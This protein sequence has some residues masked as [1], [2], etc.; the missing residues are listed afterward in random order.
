M[1]ILMVSTDD[2]VFKQPDE[3]GNTRTR[4]RDYL[5]RLNDIEPGSMI[6]D[7]VSTRNLY[8]ELT[9]NEGLKFIPVHVPTSLLFPLS[10]LFIA[11]R[12]IT[13]VPDLVTSQN[14]FE[15]GLLAWILSLIYHIPLE[16]QVHLNLF[17]PYWL[18]E[19][20]WL[21]KLRLSLAKFLTKRARVIR[22]VQSSLQ[23]SM[24]GSW[25]LPPESV[26]LIPV[27]VFLNINAGI[28]N[29]VQKYKFEVGRKFI[30]FIGRL[31][32]AK[33]LPGLFSIIEK[34]LNSRKDV[35]F[36]IIGDG[37]DR[38]FVHSK[39][40]KLGIDNIHWLG[41]LSYNMLPYYYKNA[42]IVVLPSLYEGF[43]R[44]L[45]EAYLCGTP[46]VATRCGG[47]ED[48]IIDQQTGFLTDIEDIDGFSDK[49]NWML[50]HPE[51]ARR[52][53]QHGREHVIN[54]FNPEILADDIVKQ[55]QK[56]AKR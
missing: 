43:G 37:I 15:A 22:V 30:L 8:K 33:N 31:C 3:I 46:A 56:T 52:M 9:L 7:L 32:F 36:L 48:I 29:S 17:S 26:S 42:S 45:V 20:R 14:P 4:L 47:P 6:T 10:G 19:H 55:W 21:N 53:G 54:Q 1:H 51:E 12:K 25:H 11:L 27:P 35:D 16:I 5:R 28:N 39:I 34:I 2:S 13:P 50:D 24:I 40:S 41:H 44:V 23:K 18:S 38:D 49:V